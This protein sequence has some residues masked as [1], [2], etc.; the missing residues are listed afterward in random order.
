MLFEDL[1]VTEKFA[2]SVRDVLADLRNGSSTL[3]DKTVGIVAQMRQT[4]ASLS[5]PARAFVDEVSLS[6][7]LYNWSYNSF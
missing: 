6:F 3:Y 7:Q 1:S 4:I 2:F 5:K